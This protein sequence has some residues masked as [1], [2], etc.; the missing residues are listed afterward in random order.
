MLNH[1][2]YYIAKF[3]CADVPLICKKDGGILDKFDARKSP[4]NNKRKQHRAENLLQWNKSNKG[5]HHD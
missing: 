4:A 1:E 5:K 2:K 3:L